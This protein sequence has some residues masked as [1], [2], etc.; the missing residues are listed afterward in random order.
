[1]KS[2]KLS[3]KRNLSSLYTELETQFEEARK[4]WMKANDIREEDL[5]AAAEEEDFFDEEDEEEEEEDNGEEEEDDTEFGEEDME[6][7]D[8]EEDEEESPKRRRKGG[9]GGAKG[10]HP[11]EVIRRSLFLLSLSP[12]LS[13]SHL[14]LLLYL[15]PLPSFKESCPLQSHYLSSALSIFPLSHPFL[16][17]PHIAS[18]FSLPLPPCS[19]PFLLLSLSSSSHSLILTPLPCSALIHVCPTGS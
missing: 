7:A 4:K 10:T 15:T 8:D 6:G 3:L 16:S 14:S 17:L 1:M 5:D 12:F 9:N 18:F 2:P 11:T 19:L 13:T